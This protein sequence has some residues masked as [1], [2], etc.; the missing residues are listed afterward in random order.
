MK[1]SEIV[2]RALER[3]GRWLQGAERAS[4]DRRWDDVVYGAQMC[5]EQ[6]AKAVLL[7]Y[8]IDYPK[9]HDVSDM[10]LSL[11]ERVDVPVWFQKQVG[12]VAEV[13]AELAGKRGVAAYGYGEGIGVEYFK[14]YAPQALA[15]SRVVF[16]A[17]RKLL[18]GAKRR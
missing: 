18:T 6:A 13:V 14:S 3:A 1:A 17:C 5:V 4:E 2:V 15:Q 16:E 10:V 11:A 12:K 8:G 7:Q 9:E